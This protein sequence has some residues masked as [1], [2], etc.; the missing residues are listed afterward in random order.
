MPDAER[1]PLHRLSFALAFAFGVPL[2]FAVAGYL[3]LQV[4]LLIFTGFARPGHENVNALSLQMYLF[5]FKSSSASTQYSRN[6]HYTAMKAARNI[7]R[8]L[9]I[10][11]LY[12]TFV[13]VD[14]MLMQKSMF[15]DKPT[16][17]DLYMFRD[18]LESASEIT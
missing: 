3:T 17:N 4:V 1:G 8:C 11:Q 16:K 6:E 10:R 9:L 2:V 18:V 15:L 7:D 14:L 5:E 13:I 12:E